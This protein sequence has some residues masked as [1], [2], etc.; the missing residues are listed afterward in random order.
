MPNEC[1]G[2]NFGTLVSALGLRLVYFEKLILQLMIG[3][4]EKIG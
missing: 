3:G 4:I 1:R 2:E